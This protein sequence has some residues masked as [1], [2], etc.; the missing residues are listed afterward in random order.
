MKINI[1]LLKQLYLID[2]LSGEEYNMISFILNYCHH[3]P[4]ITYSL[5]RAN[6]LF[7]TKN[8]SNPDNYICLVA[9]MDGVNA[10]SQSR[11]LIFNKNIV[12]ARY[13]SSKIQC[14]LNADK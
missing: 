2:H 13:I 7:I 12:T 5:D 4:N 11:E 14:G 3:I 1:E 8:S 9:H 6:N 10:F